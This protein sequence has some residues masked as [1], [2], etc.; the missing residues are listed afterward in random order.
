[1]EALDDDS[2]AARMRAA[3]VEQLAACQRPDGVWVEAAAW[4]VTASASG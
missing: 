1:M 2:V 3:M 4:L